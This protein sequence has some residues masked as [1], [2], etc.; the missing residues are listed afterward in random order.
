MIAHAFLCVRRDGCSCAADR[1]WW[2]HRG[3]HS[4]S[5]QSVDRSA[6]SAT[7]ESSEAG[8]SRSAIVIRAGHHP[9]HLDN[10]IR[11]PVP[12]GGRQAN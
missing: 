1:L 6:G 5:D 11:V 8:D 12:T 9:A 3:G 7:I 4:R 10:R 2:M